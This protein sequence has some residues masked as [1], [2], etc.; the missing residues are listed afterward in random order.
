[1]YNNQN[2]LGGGQSLDYVGGTDPND[3]KN[4]GSLRDKLEAADTERRKAAE[5]AANRERAAEMAREERLAK[6]RYMMEMP[7]DT[8]AG[9]G[10]L[11]H[12]YV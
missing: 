2:P 12:T 1:M 5:A 10:K 9:T 4:Y 3:Q 6:I 11:S 8:P 7:D